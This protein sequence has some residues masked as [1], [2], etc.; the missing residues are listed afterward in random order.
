MATRANPGGHHFV[1]LN[2]SINNT[3]VFVLAVV[4]SRTPDHD[5]DP[6]IGDLVAPD[7]SAVDAGP[8]FDHRHDVPGGAGGGVGVRG[9]ASDAH[10]A[11]AA[12]FTELKLRRTQVAASVS[13][14]ALPVSPMRPWLKHP[15]SRCHEKNML[16]FFDDRPQRDAYKGGMTVA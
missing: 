6:V 5:D 14:E 1:V 16:R 15:Q 3:P 12:A 7:L 11:V 9:V 13:F 10:G 8:H 4:Q 2:C